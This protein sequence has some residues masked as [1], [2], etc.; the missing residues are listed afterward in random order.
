MRAQ[1]TYA[2]SLELGQTWPLLA[3]LLGLS[4]R[5]FRLKPGGFGRG[6]AMDSGTAKQ[7]LIN[8]K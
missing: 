6:E 3:C 7:V 1:F 5:V 4:I 8:S 2:A